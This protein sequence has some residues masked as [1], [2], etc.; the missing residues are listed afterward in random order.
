MD[1]MLVFVKRVSVDPHRT[2]AVLKNVVALLGD[3]GTLFGKRLSNVLKESFV[4]Q[5][6][7][8]ASEDEDMLEIVDWTKQVSFVISMCHICMS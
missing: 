6:L 2:Q 4:A 5:L 7:E 8:Q 3:L 1:K